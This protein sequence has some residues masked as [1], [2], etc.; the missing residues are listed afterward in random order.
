MVAA[1]LATASSCSSNLAGL[2]MGKSVPL[3]KST[4]SWVLNDLFLSYNKCLWALLSPLLCLLIKYLCLV[5]SGIC[6]L[7]WGCASHWLWREDTS[8]TIS[9]AVWESYLDLNS[10]LP[11]YISGSWTH[12]IR[13]KSI[14][15][16]NS[17]L[18]SLLHPH[19]VP[20][21][22]LHQERASW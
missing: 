20:S 7:C 22:L 4:R 15:I 6:T 14:E 21:Q 5:R 16:W 18:L 13:A 12:K 9:M 19:S 17:V 10:Q 2:Q 3:V 1:S 11:P 8:P